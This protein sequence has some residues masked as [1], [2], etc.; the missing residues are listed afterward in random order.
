MEPPGAISL[1]T[2]SEGFRFSDISSLWRYT[3]TVERMSGSSR[4]SDGSMCKRL[5]VLLNPRVL[6]RVDEVSS[7]NVVRQLVGVKRPSCLLLN[8][9]NKVRF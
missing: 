6:V 5:K 4:G 9:E 2:S 3:V 1:V 8:E 7:R